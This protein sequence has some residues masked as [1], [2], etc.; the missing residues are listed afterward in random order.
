MPSPMSLLQGRCRPTIESSLKGVGHGECNK[1]TTRWD[2]KWTALST[3]ETLLRRGPKA[4]LKR[5]AVG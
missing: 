5:V 3:T 1:F 2:T 4:G